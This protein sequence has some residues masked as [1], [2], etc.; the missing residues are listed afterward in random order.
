MHISLEPT[1][2][3]NVI[4]GVVCSS[5]LVSIIL[6]FSHFLLI[7]V[8]S[9]LSYIEV[10]PSFKYVGTSTPPSHCQL[11]CLLA[12]T[13]QSFSCKQMQLTHSHASS[14]MSKSFLG[15]FCCKIDLFFFFVGNPNK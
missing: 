6:F 4:R 13:Y 14:F 5:S 11:N 12:S 7:N 15:H 3:L 8:V 10:I 2:D 1:F 9:F